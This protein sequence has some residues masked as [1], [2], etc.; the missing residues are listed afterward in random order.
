MKAEYIVLEKTKHGNYFFKGS[1]ETIEE[2]Q[3]MKKGLEIVNS[4]SKTQYAYHIFC[5]V[6]EENI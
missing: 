1:F 6:A 3:Q 2:A 4:V 5:N